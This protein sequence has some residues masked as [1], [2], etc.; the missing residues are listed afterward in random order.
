MQD[1]SFIFGHFVVVVVVVVVVN[2]KLQPQSSETQHNTHNTNNKSRAL[3][4]SCFGFF[5]DAPLGAEMV[6]FTLRRASSRFEPTLHSHLLYLF[7]TVDQL[8]YLS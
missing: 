4:K 2:L 5:S 7:V 3:L 6:V 1:L 8:L